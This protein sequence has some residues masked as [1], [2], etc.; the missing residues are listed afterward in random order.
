MEYISIEHQKALAQQYR[1]AAIIVVAFCISVLV[2]LIIAKFITI[3]DIK[4]G[5]EPWAQPVYSAVIVL[6]VVVVAL[7]RILMSKTM[8]ATAKQRGAIAVLRHLFTI[9]VIIC[10]LAEIAAIGGLALYLITGD[11]QY[12]WR[13]GVV[14]LFLLLYTFPRKSEWERAVADSAKA[15]SGNAP[16]TAQ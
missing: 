3:D 13:L 15:R 8:M 1:T 10:A 5:T 4:P 12:S 16:S 2:Y 11:Y 7:R 14:S 6:G 9:T